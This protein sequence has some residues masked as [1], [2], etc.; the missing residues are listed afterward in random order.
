MKALSILLF[1]P[2]V[3]SQL[4]PSQPLPGQPLNPLD[5]LSATVPPALPGLQPLGTNP[6]TN[7]LGQT[8]NTLGQPTNTLGQ[9]TNVLGQPTLGQPAL[10]QNGLNTNLR[11][12]RSLFNRRT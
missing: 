11:K 4:L 2:L 12:R 9:P 7:P 10:G 5:P 1:A 3:L 6:L 8:T